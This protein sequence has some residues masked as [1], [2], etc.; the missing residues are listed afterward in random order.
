MDKIK[1]LEDMIRVSVNIN[2]IEETDLLNKLGEIAYIIDNQIKEIE[3]LNI[4]LRNK[5]NEL[6]SKQ[7]KNNMLENMI[8][9]I[10][11]Y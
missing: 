1:E 3:S 6:I 9:G 7:N 4:R 10:I 8:R 5:E 2:G 11:E